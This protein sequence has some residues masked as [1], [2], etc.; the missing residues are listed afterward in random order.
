VLPVRFARTFG[1]GAATPSFVIRLVVVSSLAAVTPPA[2][3]AQ[4]ITFDGRFSPAQTFGGQ[5]QDPDVTLPALYI[6]GRDISPTSST[7]GSP[8]Q[9]VRAQQTTARLM[10]HCGHE[11]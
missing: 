11:P 8:P 9:P 6:V 7:A 2:A 4:H 1:R 5:P 10:M 3:L